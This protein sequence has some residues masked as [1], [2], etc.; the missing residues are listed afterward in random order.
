MDELRRRRT[1]IFSQVAAHR[2]RRTALVLFAVVILAW[3]LN[4]TVVKL[5]LES[6]APL[7]MIAIRSGLAAAVLLATIVLTVLALI[8]E[9][10]PVTVRNTRP[11]LLFGHGGVFGVAL[12]YW[13]L[14]MIIGGIAIGT[15]GR[16]RNCG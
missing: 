7:W 11:V 6:V 10:L 12:D 9:G 13:A 16:P 15:I 14:A 1:V 2:C 4:W 5:T 8:F 3:G